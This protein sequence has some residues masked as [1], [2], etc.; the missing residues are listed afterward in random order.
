MRYPLI[1]I[2]LVGLIAM[3]PTERRVEGKIERPHVADILLSE[4]EQHNAKAW[5]D[6]RVDYLR[7]MAPLHQL[8]VMATAT[9][10]LISGGMILSYIINSVAAIL[11]MGV[12]VA[13]LLPI[14]MLA[15]MGLLVGWKKPGHA[16]MARVSKH[17]EFGPFVSR[18]RTRAWQKRFAKAA[19]EHR[20]NRFYVNEY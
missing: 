3:L 11:G 7:D 5:V 6:G 2:I 1:L 17:T 16:W 18:M 19:K 12:S 8:L 20:F 10:L 4:T 15:L 9:I 13:V 14:G